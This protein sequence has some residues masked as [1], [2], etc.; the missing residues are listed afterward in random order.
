MLTFHHE[1]LWL[2]TETN[3]I[4]NTQETILYEF[5]NY[6]F[7]ITA[8][9]PMSLTKHGIKVADI[10]LAHLVVKTFTCILSHHILMNWCWDGVSTKRLSHWQSWKFPSLWKWVKWP[11]SCSDFSQEL[12]DT[13]QIT[14]IPWMIAEISILTKGCHIDSHDGHEFWIAIIHCLV[15][16]IFILQEKDP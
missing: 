1:V 15:D 14:T 10:L 6:T 12:G 7:K 13:F 11:C 4:A 16:E 8:T 9:F 2:S 3:F 5:I